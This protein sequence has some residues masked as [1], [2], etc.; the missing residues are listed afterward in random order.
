MF[1]RLLHQPQ[2]VGKSFDRRRVG[3]HFAHDERHRG[4]RGS[5]LMR[6]RRCEAIDL[7]QVL[8]AGENE[9]RRRQR[10]RALARLLRDAVRVEGH[11]GCA[12]GER[13]PARNDVERRKDQ[14]FAAD[15]RQ[16][17]AHAQKHGSA[18]ERQSEQRERL[19]Q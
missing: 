8:G 18:D 10:A 13:D 9:L 5:E 4:E 16:R 1:D 3:R 11:K 6:R 15:P 12:D 17:Q 14:V 19:P 2:I 7:G